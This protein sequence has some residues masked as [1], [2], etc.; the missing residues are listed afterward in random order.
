LYF[1]ISASESVF[2]FVSLG[3]STGLDHA[4]ITLFRLDA[5]ELVLSAEAPDVKFT[6][7]LNGS[8]ANDDAHMSKEPIMMIVMRVGGVWKVVQS[9]RAFSRCA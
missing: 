1:L 7:T 6:D 5:G 4:S 3:F 8:F 9:R 2:T